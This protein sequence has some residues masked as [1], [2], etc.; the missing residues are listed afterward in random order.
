VLLLFKIALYTFLNTKNTFFN[1]ETVVK[2]LQKKT[3][4]LMVLIKDFNMMIWKKAIFNSFRRLLKV[5]ENGRLKICNLVFFARSF[6]VP[7]Y[8]SASCCVIY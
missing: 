4:P 3:K 7:N 5:F 1:L 8:P 6:I 2:T